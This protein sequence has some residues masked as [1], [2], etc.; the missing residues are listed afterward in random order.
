[1]GHL[2]KAH[3]NVLSTCKNIAEYNSINWRQIF[4]TQA[5]KQG[6]VSSTFILLRIKSKGSNINM[7]YWIITHQKQSLKA[8]LSWLTMINVSCL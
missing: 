7:V 8:F 5:S 3:T 1:M 2:S 6:N 4:N